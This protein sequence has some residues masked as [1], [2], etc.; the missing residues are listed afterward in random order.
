[1][2]RLCA[3]CHM[4]LMYSPVQEAFVL[5]SQL[6][7]CS[8]IFMCPWFGFIVLCMPIACCLL[9]TVILTLLNETVFIVHL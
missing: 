8:A 1:M 6:E 2:T 3:K 5:T 4:H 7:N 9:F